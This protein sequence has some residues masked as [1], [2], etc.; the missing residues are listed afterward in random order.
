MLLYCFVPLIREEFMNKRP[1]NLTAF[2]TKDE[3]ISFKKKL[4]D[5]EISIKDFGTLIATKVIQ[6]ENFLN[7]VLNA[8]EGNSTA[9]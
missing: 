1:F 8:R 3:I 5:S 7:G 6:D 2:L 4:L 9:A